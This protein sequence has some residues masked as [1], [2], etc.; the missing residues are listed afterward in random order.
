MRGVGGGHRP[1]DGDHRILE[2]LRIV[3]GGRLHRGRG[4]DLHQ[5]VHD[6]VP[7]RPHGVVEVSAVLDAEALRHRDLHARDGVPVP[8]R[9]EHH[10]R[11]SQVQDLREAH[12][13]QEVVDP[14][15]LRLVDVAVDLFGQ[16]AGRLAIVTERLL[17]DHARVRGQSRLGESLDDRAEE[18]RAGSP[19]RTPGCCAPLIAAASRS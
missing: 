11:E 18:E 19:D 4:H 5:V 15:E 16:G 17:H 8:D 12:L 9:L 3:R 7:K 6:H 13:S 10:V 1:E 14:V 2:R